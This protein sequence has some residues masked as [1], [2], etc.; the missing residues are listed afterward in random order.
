MNDIGVSFLPRYVV[1]DELLHGS[2]VEISTNIEHREIS[3]VC[4]YHKNKWVSP[5][6]TLFIDSLM[7]S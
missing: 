1:E 7:R 3:A 6:M 5:L 4:A 2:L